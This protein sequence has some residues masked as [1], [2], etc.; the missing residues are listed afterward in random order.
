MRACSDARCTTSTRV[1]GVDTLQS[2]LLQPGTTIW[3]F[4]W[5]Q[6]NASIS[7]A[8]GSASD[9]DIVLYFPDGSFTGLGGFNLNIGGD[10]V[11]VFGV[12]LG[13][14][15]PL[16]VAIGLENCG[17]PDPSLMKYVYF[18]SDRRFGLGPMEYDTASPTSYGHANAQGAIATGASAWFNT[19]AWNDNPACDPA[20]LNGLSSAGGVPIL[21]DLEGNRVAALR[22][23]PEIVGPDGANN[24]FFGFDLSFPI[25]G[26]DEPD[27]FPNFFGTSASAPHLAGVAALMS[28]PTVNGKQYYICRETPRKV[29]TRR[30]GAK[31]AEKKSCLR[32]VDVRR[33]CRGYP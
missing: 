14:A 9:M 30:V 12:A 13:G 18:G 2:F 32:E 27:G 7:G 24:T 17:G 26:T 25:P 23:K 1:R 21:F 11:E 8:P 31:A 28:Q 10:A 29:K 3:S 22:L 4:Q 5:D 6:P 16:E 15:Q 19:A 20:C 33:L